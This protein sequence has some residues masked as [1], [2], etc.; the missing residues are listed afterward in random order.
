MENLNIYQRMLKI[1]AEVERVAKNL[2]VGEYKG[3]YKAVGEADVL[4][5]IKPL[6][7][8]YGVYS[9]PVGREIVD[10][11][12]LVSKSTY[13]GQDKE[14]RRLYVRIRT[15][16]RFVNVDN[17]DE[18]ISIDTYGDGV[19]SQDK[20]PGKAMTYA[21]KYALLKAYKIMT[22]DDPDT[23][24]SEPLVSTGKQGR[25]TKT[26]TWAEPYSP[27]ALE[28][29]KGEL[30]KIGVNVPKL[31][32]SFDCKSMGMLTKEQYEQIVAMVNNHRQKVSA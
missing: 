22:G 5:A 7:E 6:E 24:K 21:D 28:K 11:G 19:D 17:P 31:L 23:Q 26:Q 13:N 4:A 10:S 15:V 12:E 27:D 18:S 20:A 3:A 9:Y 30:E 14:T 2:T 8:K 29:L 1:S 25:Q 16:Y 32:Q